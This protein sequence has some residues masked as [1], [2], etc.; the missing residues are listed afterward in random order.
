[1][2]LVPRD[3]ANRKQPMVFAGGTDGEGRPLY[4]PILPP[5]NDGSRAAMDFEEDFQPGGKYYGK[6][7]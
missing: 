5:E 1:M 6:V 4:F 2:A 3:A 7:N